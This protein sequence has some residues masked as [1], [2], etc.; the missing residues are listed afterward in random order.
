[1]RIEHW[2]VAF[3]QGKTAALNMLGRDV[4][5]ETVP[6]FYSVLGDWGELEY[7][8]PAYGWD[9]EILRGS[10]DDGAF[11]NWYLQDGRVVAALTFGRSDDLDHA[12]RLLA[13]KPVLD[14]S[15]RA[16]LA[17]ADSELSA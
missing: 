3:N 12:R 2:D 16:A 5:H 6:Y 11:T 9:E 14:A 1:V 10:F 4:A 15:R 17:D 7:V 13:E 8:G